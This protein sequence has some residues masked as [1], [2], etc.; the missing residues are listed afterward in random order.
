MSISTKF[1][2]TQPYRKANISCRNE[3]PVFIQSGENLKT[4][5]KWG[6]TFKKSSSQE[7]RSQIQRTKNKFSINNPYGKENI[8]CR[9]YGLILF[10]NL[11][12]YE[13]NNKGKACF[14][15]FITSGSV[16]H[17]S[18]TKRVD[19]TKMDLF[20]VQQFACERNIWNRQDTLVPMWCS[21]YHLTMELC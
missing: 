13:N 5:E 8:N 17:T 18:K 7:I 11:R 16:F 1:G 9:N 14:N 20:A 10:S 4:V 12:F 3:R 21:F 15:Q 2:T 6:C 19:L